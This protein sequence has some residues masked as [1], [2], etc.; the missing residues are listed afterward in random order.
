M[1]ILRVVRATAPKI[2]V[3]ENVGGLVTATHREFFE[4]VISMLTCSERNPRPRHPNPPRGGGNN[5]LATG[6]LARRVVARGVW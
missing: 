6:L 4:A 3:L 2:V 1:H 5:A